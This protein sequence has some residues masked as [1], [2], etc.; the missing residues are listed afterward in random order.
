MFGP[1]GLVTN[2][3][4]L[5]H[6]LGFLLGKG[7]IAGQDISGYSQSLWKKVIPKDWI[8][9]LFYGAGWYIQEN[10]FCEPLI[11]HGGDLL[12]SGGICMLLPQ[13]RL[14]IVLGQNAAGSSIGFDFACAV[15]R[16][17]KQD[18]A[19]PATQFVAKRTSCSTSPSGSTSSESIAACKAV[20]PSDDLAGL[21]KNRDGIYSVEAIFDEGML[22][23]RPQVPGVV[24]LPEITFSVVK[25]SNE[26]VEFKPVGYPSPSKRSG[27]V[28]LRSIGGDQIWLQYENY[29]FLRSENRSQTSA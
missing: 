22:K 9:G 27:C 1:G 3:D 18:G 8:P 21:Y 4:D 29:L 12:F 14:G 13:S 15:L 26:I 17:L 24:S 6:Y 10:E 20:I 23:L 16:L 2:I 25:A 19:Q 5:S 11:Y 7:V 28:F